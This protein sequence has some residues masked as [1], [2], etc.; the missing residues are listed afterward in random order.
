MTQ[1]LV[2]TSALRYASRDLRAGEEFEASDTDAFILTKT[3]KAI[4]KAESK[5]G[6]EPE[7]QADDQPRKRRYNRRDMRAEQ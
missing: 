1:R 5:A 7:S 4:A 2:T 3:G 6:V